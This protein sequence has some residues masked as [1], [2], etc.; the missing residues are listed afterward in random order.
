MKNE[1][2]SGVKING[3]DFSVEI[4]NMIFNLEN[5]SK[6]TLQ[7]YNELKEVDLFQSGNIDWNNLSIRESVGKNKKLIHQTEF[8]NWKNEKYQLKWKSNEK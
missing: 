6:G 7:I 5:D 3:I 4:E 2:F 1:S 8:I